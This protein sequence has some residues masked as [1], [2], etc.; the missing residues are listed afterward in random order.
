LGKDQR[1]TVDEKEDEAPIKALD[2]GDIALLK[3][4]GAGMYSTSIKRLKKISKVL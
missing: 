2:E 1:R 4:Y 3:T